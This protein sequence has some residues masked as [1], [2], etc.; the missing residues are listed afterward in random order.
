MFK[1]ESK[2]FLHTDRVNKF[3]MDAGFLSVV[4]VGQYFMTKDNGEL[5]YAKACREYTL[6]RSDGSSQQK[7]CWLKPFWLKPFSLK[8]VVAHARSADCFFFR[9][10]SVLGGENNAHAKGVERSPAEVPSPASEREVDIFAG[11]SSNEPG[12]EWR[13]QNIWLP[14]PWCRRQCSCKKSQKRKTVEAIK[15]GRVEA[16][17][18]QSL[19][20]W[21]CSGESRSWS[22][23]ETHC[24]PPC[25]ECGAPVHGQV[26][27]CKGGS[28]N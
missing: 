15:G 4:E 23:N 11:I 25:K 28:T 12:S 24:V 5:F 19:V 10:V 16:C 17:H 6:P 21:S 22:K 20:W 26:P 2:V 3:C 13:R 27:S 9:W 1:N 18:H 7:G 14:R 8:A